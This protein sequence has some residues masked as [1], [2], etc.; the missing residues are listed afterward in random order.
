MIPNQSTSASNAPAT[1]AAWLEAGL[2]YHRARVF[3]TAIAAF[4]AGLA[5]TDAQGSDALAS[6]ATQLHFRLANVAMDVGDLDLA[7]Q[8]YKQALLIDLN[9]IYCWCNLGNVFVRKSRPAEAIPYYTQALNLDAQHLPTRLNLAQAL[10]AMQQWTMAKSLL[11]DL[12][13]ECP[14]EP[15]VRNLLGKVA[16]GLDDFAT[17]AAAFEMA[18][19]LNPTDFDSIYWLGSVRQSIGQTDA[20]EA[21]YA[22]AL[23]LDPLIHKPA[24]KFPPD[25]TVLALYAPMGGNT[26]TEYLFDTAAHDT[27]TYAVLGAQDHDI[28]L[29]RSSGDIVVNLISDADQAALILPEAV[30][31]ADMLGRIVINHPSEILQTTRERVA[32][33]L[34]GL[35]H[36]RVPKSVRIDAITPHAHRIARSTD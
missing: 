30:I 7:E 21:A 20:A 16:V 31:L 26:P 11:T 18:I 8:H 3:D 29:L 14:D 17:A 32:A 5:L 13:S 25:F 35:P 2:A 12:A 36:V 9:L 33:R 23:R 22:A 28:P 27:N 10:I 34:T 6:E 15:Q 1:P 4:T 24:A 19:A